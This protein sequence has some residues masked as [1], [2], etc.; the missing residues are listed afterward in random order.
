M[1]TVVAIVCAL[2][3]VKGW[4]TDPVWVKVAADNSSAEA[5]A[6]ADFVC[7]GTN[8]QETIQ[9]AIDLCAKDGRN[10]YLYNGVYMI[11]AFRDWKD[12]GPRAAVRI[13]NMLR[14][15]TIEGQEFYQ[16]GHGTIPENLNECRNG[17]IWYARP[18]VW[19]TAGDDVPSVLRGEW[20]K[21]SSQNGSGLCLQ[22]VSVF[23]CD[24]QHP[25]RCVD[26]RWTDAVEVRNMRLYGIGYRIMNGDAHPFKKFGPL[27]MPHID[28]IGLTMT[29]G[30][31]V[32]VSRF[33]N[34]AAIGF[35]QGF[36]VGGEHVICNDCLALRGL[37]GWTFGNYK[38]SAGAHVHPIVLVN[39]ADEQNVNMPLFANESQGDW[40]HQSVT[41]IGCNFEH[42]ES[43][44]IGGK[45]GDFM[46]ETVPGSWR[47]HIEY[48]VM[49]REA[50][51]NA[52][53]FPLWENDGSGSGF[54]TRNLAHK[55]IGPSEERRK[56]SPHLGQQYFDTDL[57]KLLVCTDPTTRK[58]VDA[59]GV[60]VDDST[61][62][63]ERMKAIYEE[64]KTPHKVGMA[65]EPEE[66]EMLDNPMVFRHGR[67][68]YMMFIR[69]DGKGYETHLAKS[70][71]LK[72]WTRLGRIFSRG[73]KGAW[74]A[75]Q[76]D[77]WPML[78]DTSWEGSNQ[79]NTFGGKYWMMYLG[80]AADG[81]ETDPLSTGVAWTDDPSAVRE[82]TRYEGNPVMR[83]SDP[84][85]RDFERKTIYKHFTVD[86]PSRSCGGRFVNFYNAKSPSSG[87]EAIGM[88]VSDDMLHWRRVGDGPVIDNGDPS[89]HVIS[90]D[91]MTRR[92]GDV[93]VM[94]YFGWK[95]KEGVKGAFDTFACS[96]DLKHWTKW[97][98]EPLVK[99]SEGYD[100][101]HAH[102]PWVLKHDG[103]VYHWYCAVRKQNG[104]EVRGIALATSAE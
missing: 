31:N 55:R 70:D 82:W 17:V 42:M 85:A 57:G 56:Y 22:N 33:D 96:Y 28:A 51:G 47:G 93:W 44:M 68:W 16:A 99:P 18:T 23:M 74:D 87:R 80:G 19:T 102:K 52:V 84:D 78:V 26:L 50:S 20:C 41:M 38:Y 1:R 92:I 10:L 95:W 63:P 53:E 32:P 61:V 54:E 75:A 34:I 98:G 43:L 12:G 21:V 27:Q 59:M 11:D 89:Q 72:K 5:K 4:A 103:V 67:A 2:V 88:A 73:E 90:G 65:L 45:L 62:S 48:T 79:L 104:R 7:S 83:P 37:Y 8:D 64:V 66:G 14:R 100:G 86:D 29:S 97:D 9:A 3:A 13:P 58:W 25:A 101:A 91:P 60:P 71:D 39:C 94:F 24:A 35:G 76:A 30:S 15:F 36:Q 77:G 6:A 81:Y 40:R 69:F 46:R 49:P